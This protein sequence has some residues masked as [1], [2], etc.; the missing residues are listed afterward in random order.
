V[1]RDISVWSLELREKELVMVALRKRP[2]IPAQI[3]SDPSV[4]SG[5]PVVRGT[6]VQASTI[7]AYLRAGHSKR[8]I[9]EDYPS[10]PIDGIDAVMAWAEATY[11]PDW[12]RE[13]AAAGPT[14]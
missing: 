2:V 1:A 5:A 13:P 7:L 10:L 9:F 11:G 3:V 4:M 8:E 6:R 14:H 12:K